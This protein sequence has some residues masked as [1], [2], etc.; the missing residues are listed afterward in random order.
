M[1]SSALFGA[2]SRHAARRCAPGGPAG[3]APRPGRP[4]ESPIVS[5]GPAA[6][7]CS[8][9]YPN[10]ASFT[11]LSQNIAG[12]GCEP[13][14]ASHE[15]A[16]Q[17]RPLIQT[18]HAPSIPSFCRVGA[19]SAAI[20]RRIAAPFCRPVGLRG[21]SCRLPA[22]SRCP[23]VP[24][25]GGSCLPSAGR[26]R[27]AAPFLSAAGRSAFL[28]GRRR[29][30]RA[31]FRL[32]PD[33]QRHSAADGDCP[34]NALAGQLDVIEDEY[35]APVRTLPAR[36]PV[37]AAGWGAEIG[38]RSAVLD[39]LRRAV[40]RRAIGRPI[41]RSAPMASS[42][43]RPRPGCRAGTPCPRP[44]PAQPGLPGP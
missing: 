23:F 3:V 34:G 19:P 9:A 41:P 17:D 29:A 44:D 25:A 31:C 22:G 30:P 27:I 33:R 5:H 18:T 11:L 35:G 16:S 6:S 26:G 14:G 36:S 20:S 32:V 10:P 7:S 43:R 21:P 39:A 8:G 13:F 38:T 12:P 4:D 37:R 40:V 24:T 28:A 42:L 15:N 1:P 2:S